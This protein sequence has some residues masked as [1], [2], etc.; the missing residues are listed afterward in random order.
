MKLIKLSHCVYH[1]DYHLVIVTKYRK[2]IFNQGIF[3][4]FDIKLAEISSHYPQIQF[5]EVNHDKD[6]IHLLVS[7]PPTMKVGKVVGIIKQNTAK[8]L[9]KKFTFIKDVYWGTESVWS[10]GYFVSTVGINESIIKKYIKEQG[11]KD[12]G[13]TLFEIN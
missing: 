2:K 12:S 4:Y 13:Q 6:H 11:K 7:I 9:K 3:S 5:K 8:E 10:E 1:C